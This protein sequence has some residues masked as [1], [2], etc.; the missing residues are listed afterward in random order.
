MNDKEI[1]VP[2]IDEIFEKIDRENKTIYINAPDGLIDIY[3]S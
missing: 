3:L 1:L 2:A